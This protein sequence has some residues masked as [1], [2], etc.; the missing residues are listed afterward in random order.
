[1][2]LIF[3]F[4]PTWTP[5][6]TDEHGNALPDSVASLEKIELGGV[7]QSILIRGKDRSNPVVLFLH[8]G[9]GY[10]Q[11]AYA[12]RYL[13]GLENDFVVVNWDQRGAGK[14]YHW[15]LTQDDM[16][17]DTLI[18]DTRE[19]TEYLKEKFQQP[20]IYLVGHSSGSM[21]ATWTVQKYPELYYAY[22][23]V[24]QVA[25]SPLGELVS[26]QSVLKEAKRRN[27]VEA[28]RELEAIGAPPY[29]IP[30]EDAT[31]ER[32][33]VMAFGGSERGSDT[34]AAMI[35]GILLAPEY[36]WSDGIRLAL[37]DS[38]SRHAIL[39]QTKDVKLADTV[40]ELEVPVIFCMGRHDWMTPSAVAYSY[41][42]KLKAPEK[43][44]I[45]F[46]QSAHFPHF[47]E[48]EK[49]H[50]VLLELRKNW[51]EPSPL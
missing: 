18:E 45:W 39:P 42:E 31:L 43:Q 41:Y 10:P 11:I 27:H 12:R 35:E 5:S 26:Y 17:I 25:D 30:R 13:S 48:P 23:G 28:V 20:K 34:Y 40:P 46:E 21:L 51:N 4:F 47:E 50:E 2:L 3:W 16:K 49:F 14:S 37:G 15:N 32:K 24:G 1:L 6:L 33:W 19:L 8:G 22:I 44:F 9:P 29:R 36:S 38:F 7:K